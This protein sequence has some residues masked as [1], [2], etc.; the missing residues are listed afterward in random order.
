MTLNASKANSDHLNEKQTV[1][2]YHQ[3]AGEHL[4]NASVA[5]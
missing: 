4:Q 3:Q 2:Q 1:Q 5:T